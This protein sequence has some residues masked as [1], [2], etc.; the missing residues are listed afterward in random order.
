[1]IH[2]PLIFVVYKEKKNEQ[3]NGPGIWHF[4]AY[5]RRSMINDLLNH[6]KE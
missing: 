2:K 3:Q 5:S 1:M 6:M 4:R